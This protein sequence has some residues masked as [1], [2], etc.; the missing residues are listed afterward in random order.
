[1]PIGQIL[2]NSSLVGTLVFDTKSLN[3]TG[4]ANQQIKPLE[5]GKQT[6]L[7]SSNSAKFGENSSE[8]GSFKSGF[9]GERVSTLEQI[10]K[11]GQNLT[12]APA[13]ESFPS[14][15]SS[16]DLAPSSQAYNFVGKLTSES[17]AATGSIFSAVA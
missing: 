2:S 13:K 3:N 5:I 16:L 17:S 4:I 9:G 11:P 8:V 15:K 10:T 1:M 12:L 14:D 6:P 7:Y